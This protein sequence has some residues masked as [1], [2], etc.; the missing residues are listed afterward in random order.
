MSL[1]SVRRKG[2]Y[3]KKLWGECANVG[4][5]GTEFL[6]TETGIPDRHYELLTLLI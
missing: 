5:Q 3:Y 4:M 1:L 2:H 6:V